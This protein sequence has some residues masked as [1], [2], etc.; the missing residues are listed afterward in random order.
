MKIDITKALK[1]LNNID[2]GKY[3]HEIKRLAPHELNGLRKR[4][5]AIGLISGYYSEVDF[6]I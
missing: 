3:K 4:L 1:A 2:W 5:W 6:Q